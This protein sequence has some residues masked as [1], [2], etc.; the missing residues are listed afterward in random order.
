[1]IKQTCENKMYNETR[2]KQTVKNK[3]QNVINKPRCEIK[4]FETT[5]NMK[6]NK[7][8]QDSRYEIKM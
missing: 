8:K 1:M 6:Q 7:K 4:I 2:S 3:I 5:K